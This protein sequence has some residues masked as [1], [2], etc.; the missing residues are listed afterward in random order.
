MKQ[1]QTTRVWKKV[2]HF[3]G[4]IHGRLTLTSL[5]KSVSGE[6]SWVCRC[7]CGNVKTVL[8]KI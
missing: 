2:K 1:D 3:V 7:E 5:I 8:L 4:Q 6:Q